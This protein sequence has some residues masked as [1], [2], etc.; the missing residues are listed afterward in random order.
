M[1]IK[2]MNLTVGMIVKNESKIIGN[3]LASVQ[4]YVQEIIIIDNGSE[5]ET[6]Q[7]A[8]NYATKIFEINEGTESE[9]RNV[10]IDNAN[11]DWILTLD[12]D[13]EITNE[14]WEKLD[15]LLRTVSD[16]IVSFIIPIYNY[17]G[18]GKWAHFT[19]HKL[20]RKREKLFY[21]G[22]IHQSITKRIYEEKLDFSLFNCPIHH[23]DS[24]IKNRSNNKR[25][26]YLKRIYNELED[27][28]DTNHYYRLH[29]YLAVEYIANGNFDKAKGLLATVIENS[30]LFRKISQIYYIQLA[31]L[32]KDFNQAREYLNYIIKD[33]DYILSMESKEEMLENIKKNNAISDEFLQ[34][35][36]VSIAQVYIHENKL[37]LAKYVA[38]LALDIYPFASQHYL[39][40]ASL[41]TN[42]KQ[43]NEMISRALKLN[44]YLR[45]KRIYNQGDLCNIYAFQTSLISTTE[46]ILNDLKI[47]L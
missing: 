34:R 19:S 40:V 24:L 26:S 20:F 8:Q 21:S 29:T 7:I 4:P 38:Q 30:N 41:T 13:E 36:L 37:V 14:F 27:C 12:A 42:I 16:N 23:M 31:I 32:Q 10:Y 5:D 1:A 22:K 17:F 44:P 43:R 18:D 6:Y 25:E 39:N 47:N 15:E 9:L 46:D 33:F 11:C 35:V 45:D 3:L 2:K 28:E